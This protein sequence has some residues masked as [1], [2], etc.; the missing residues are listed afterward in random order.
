MRMGML[1]D[2]GKCLIILIELE[3]R[4]EKKVIS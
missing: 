1:N 4:V 2:V 3:C